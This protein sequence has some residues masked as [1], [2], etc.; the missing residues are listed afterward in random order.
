MSAAQA[1]PADAFFQ[2]GFQGKASLHHHRLIR[3]QTFQHLNAAPTLCSCLDGMLL[4][5]A[6][7]LLHKGKEIAIGGQDC[8]FRNA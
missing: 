3:L 6:R 5:N 7:S 4:V 8:A 1:T 2:F